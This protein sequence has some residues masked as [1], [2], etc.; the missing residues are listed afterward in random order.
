MAVI[1]ENGTVWHTNQTHSCHMLTPAIA[2][3]QA[4]FIILT[5]FRV[6]GGRW[7]VVIFLQFQGIFHVI[8]DN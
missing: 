3:S 7:S 1:V 4:V 6:T 5:A 8:G 2:I